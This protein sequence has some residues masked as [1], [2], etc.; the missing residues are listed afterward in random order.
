MR[1]GRNPLSAGTSGVGRLNVEF[2]LRNAE[3]KAGGGDWHRAKSMEER[4]KSQKN[5]GTRMNIH[6]PEAGRDEHGFSSRKGAKGVKEG[7]GYADCECPVGPVAIP[8]N[9]EHNS[10]GLKLAGLHDYWSW[11]T[12]ILKPGFDIGLKISLYIDHGST[13][14]SK[15]KPA[16]QDLAARHGGSIIFSQ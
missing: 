3:G 4:A 16:H 15:N 9:V 8:G 5:D 7:R 6:P 1:Q 11:K 12:S 10:G 14:L 2:G 13:K